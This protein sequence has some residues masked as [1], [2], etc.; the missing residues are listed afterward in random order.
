ML[1]KTTSRKFIAPSHQAARKEIQKSPFNPPEAVKKFQIPLEFPFFKG[2]VLKKEN[3][4]WPPQYLRIPLF[5]VQVPL[6]AK[7]GSGEICG[8]RSG[9]PQFFHSFPFQ[10]GG[11]ESLPL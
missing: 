10:K 1:T 5:R 2:G 7:E 8:V 4:N 6:F 9:P 3:N 11:I